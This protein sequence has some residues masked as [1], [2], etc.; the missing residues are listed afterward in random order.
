MENKAKST[1]GT[2]AYLAPS[3]D[4]TIK[5]IYATALGLYNVY[6][7]LEALILSHTGD[8]NIPLAEYSLFNAS[9]SQ[10][11]ENTIALLRGIVE[12]FDKTR[13]GL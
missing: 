12:S 13:R 1:I 6:K 10:T 5:D 8:K 2:A 7:E 3:S 4:E 11:L 9:L